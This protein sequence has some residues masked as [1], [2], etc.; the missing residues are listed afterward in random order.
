MA[1]TVAAVQASSAVPIIPVKAATV[2]CRDHDGTFLA[3]YE[4]VYRGTCGFNQSL[5][6]KLRRDLVPHKLFKS[7]A[8]A[9]RACKDYTATIPRQR[10]RTHTA[11]TAR[12]IWP[13]EAR[14]SSLR[15][16]SGPPPLALR[17]RRS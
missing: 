7:Q 3:I 8:Q 1:L 9:I 6:D 4:G 5:Y 15:P 17:S 12:P 2:T 14:T 11:L 13:I 10:S 16:L